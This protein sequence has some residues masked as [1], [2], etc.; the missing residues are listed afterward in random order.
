MKY[1]VNWLD[2]SQILFLLG[3]QRVNIAF[4]LTDEY[5]NKRLSDTIGQN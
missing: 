3:L 5:K 2:I 1:L 4:S